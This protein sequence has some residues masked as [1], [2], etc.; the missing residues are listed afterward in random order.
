MIKLNKTLWKEQG[1]KND[2]YFGWVW[3][4]LQNK[5]WLKC[6]KWKVK[7]TTHLKIQINHLVDYKFVIKK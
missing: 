3:N 5:K 2:D 6:I 7:S 1:E 4:D